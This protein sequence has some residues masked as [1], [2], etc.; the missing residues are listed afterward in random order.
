MGETSDSNINQFPAFPGGGQLIHPDQA[1]PTNL[2]VIPS[3][4]PVVFPTLIAPFVIWHP[5]AIATI[6]EAMSRHKVVGFLLT[7]SDDIP[8][9]VTSADLFDVGIAARI[10]KRIKLPDGNIHVLIQGVSRFRIKQTLSQEPYIAVEPEYLEEKPLEKSIESDALSRAVINHV[11]ELSDANPFF[12]DELRLALVNASHG[13]VVADIVAFAL[14]LNKKEAQEFLETVGIQERFQKLLLHL[15]REH[16]VA[17]VQRKIN[18]EVNQKVSSLQ[19]EF[20]LKEQLKLIKKELGIEEEGKDKNARTFRERIVA[21]KMPPDVEKIALDELNRFESLQEASPEYN[22]SRNYLENLASLPWSFETEDNL[23][24]DH[25]ESVLNED[26]FGLEKVKR[27]ILEFIAVRNLQT[28]V[29]PGQKK[30][31]I[32]LLVGPPGVGKT[33]IGKSIARAMNRNFYRFS[34]GGMRDEAEIKGHRRTYIGAMP[35]KFI[36]AA[37][38]AGS[39]N[40]LILLDEID[41]IA[42]SYHGDP[43]S[44]LLEV[45]DPEQNSGFLDH[46][47]DIPFDLSQM[48]FICTANSTQTIPAPLLDR[49]EVIELSG[50]TLEEKQHIA[51]THLWPKALLKNG[52]LGA[53]VKLEPR[54]IPLLI[55]GY[56][57][58]PG[59]RQLQNQLDTLARRYAAKIVERREARERIRFPLTIKSEY[60][61]VE[62]LGP[63]RYNKETWIDE[64]K[65][66]TTIGLAWT[67][68]GGEILNLESVELAGSGQLKLTGRMGEVMVESANLAWTLVKKRLIENL[69]VTANS[70]K[71]RDIHVHIPSGAVPKDGPSAGITLATA[72]YS[73][74]SGLRPVPRLAMT[75]ELSLTGRVLAIGGVREKLL[76]ATRAGIQSVILP[77]ENKKDLHEIP[78]EVLKTIKIH[79]VETLEDVLSLALNPDE[80]VEKPLLPRI[81]PRN[82][83]TQKL[84]KKSGII[85]GK[86][87]KSGKL[88]GQPY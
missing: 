6:E 47:L 23:K 16:D 11:K 37:K 64:T 3:T 85:S 9:K 5:Q 51:D 7:R 74:F 52:L 73:L 30:G 35:G 26:H 59:L 4:G 79:F 55:R 22:I 62:A 10:L 44:A 82:R 20:F 2:F 15:K 68:L 19:R 69:V 58:E 84:R 77:R 8:D 53:Q 50:Y 36:Q 87:I 24:L 65:A 32:I 13:G 21:A 42:S 67:A 28:E 1:L 75:G 76:A 12:N 38:R 48:I 34:L 27:R 29:K 60:E 71:F 45:L 54:L 57:R 61:L 78:L 17:T 66:G 40:A 31:A 33:S 80:S 41:K 25:A 70:L 83:A 49:M 39:K 43:A 18:D 72:L 86:T 56:A 63:E 88:R 46:Y 81:Q 14:G